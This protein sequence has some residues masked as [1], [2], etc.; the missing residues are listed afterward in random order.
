MHKT[1]AEHANII[2][3]PQKIGRILNTVW[4]THR[5]T[6]KGNYYVWINKSIVTS[7]DN[8]NKVVLSLCQIHLKSKRYILV[9]A[10]YSWVYVI[11]NSIFSIGRTGRTGQLGNSFRAVSFFSED[12]NKA[13]LLFLFRY[14]V[15]SNSEIPDFL[16]K[17]A[18]QQ[19]QLQGER[20]RMLKNNSNCVITKQMKNLSVR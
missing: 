14:L 6:K 19:Q 8:S 20:R 12:N 11:Y 1:I 16:F 7:W 5:F 13:S 3:Y 4:F 17:L 15:D 18:E 2:C 9:D 10:I